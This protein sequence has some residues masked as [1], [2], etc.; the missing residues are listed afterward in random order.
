MRDRG[1]SD[2]ASGD[3]KGVVNKQSCSRRGRR[4][5]N[6]LLSIHTYPLTP[7]LDVGTNVH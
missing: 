4:P 5:G 2:E 7:V 3:E 6:V 1:S